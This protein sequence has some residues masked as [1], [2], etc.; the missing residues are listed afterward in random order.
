[1]TDNYDEL[2]EIDDEEEK[3]KKRLKMSKER[4]K[5]ILKERIKKS[6]HYNRPRLGCSKK[7]VMDFRSHVNFAYSH[8]QTGEF[9]G[10]LFA[11]FIF[12]FVIVTVAVIHEQYLFLLAPTIS[13]FAYHLYLSIRE[14]NVY[15]GFFFLLQLILQISIIFVRHHGIIFG[16]VSL[17][18]TGVHIFIRANLM[19]L[20]F[21]L[22][23]CI[24]VGIAYIGVGMKELDTFQF[25]DLFFLYFLLVLSVIWIFVN[26][27]TLLQLLFVWV[28]RSMNLFFK[29]TCCR[30]K[31]NFKFKDLYL[32]G[33][34][35]ILK[36]RLTR[37]ALPHLLLL[38]RSL[39]RHVR[40]LSLGPAPLPQRHDLHQSGRLRALALPLPA[41]LLHPAEE[42][43][44]CPEQ[45]LHAHPP[46]VLR[47]PHV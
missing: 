22:R 16:V 15:L 42:I 14:L 13:L 47:K 36:G 34:R 21:Y 11:W 35:Y 27:L 24:V 43:S 39:G 26:K 9:M 37:T 12:F 28:P 8:N 44:P 38:L 3:L 1:M 2:I 4:S 23:V 7:V 18:F 20:R 31:V 41:L 6:A 10:F 46:L 32:E 30:P 29:K 33:D 5:A 25:Q 40:R 19:S 45:G 17:L